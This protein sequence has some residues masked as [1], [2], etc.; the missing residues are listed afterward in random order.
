[1]AVAPVGSALLPPSLDDLL[2]W[3]RTRVDGGCPQFL[4]SSDLRIQQ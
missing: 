2:E 4:L 3:K 1:V